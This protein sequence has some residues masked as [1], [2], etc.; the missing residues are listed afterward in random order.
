[1]P[2]RDAFF[3]SGEPATRPLRTTLCR[4]YYICP[5][6][7]IGPPKGGVDTVVLIDHTHVNRCATPTYPPH[8]LFGRYS[9]LFWVACEV[10]PFV[11]RPLF[12]VTE[13]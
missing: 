4:A 3:R 11:F 7:S 2:E 13:I 8:S 5:I 9:A 6:H 1:M 10:L 12:V